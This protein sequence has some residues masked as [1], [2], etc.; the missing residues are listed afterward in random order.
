MPVRIFA[1]S[2]FHVTL[3]D[4]F[5][6]LRFPAVVL[7]QQLYRDPAELAIFLGNRQ[8]ET[9]PDILAEIPGFRRQGCYHSDFNRLRG[10][11]IDREKQASNY[12]YHQ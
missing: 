6:L 7:D 8:L 12:Q 9:V 10:S 2:F 5:P 1:P 4:L 11:S 3:G